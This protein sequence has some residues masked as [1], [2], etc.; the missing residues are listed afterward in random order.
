MCAEKRE[1]EMANAGRRPS[2]GGIQST[3]P[4]GAS[5]RVLGKGSLGEPGGKGPFRRARLTSEGI[6]GAYQGGPR[7][8]DTPPQDSPVPPAY[9]GSAPKRRGQVRGGNAVTHR[10]N[11]GREAHQE[12]C[13]ENCCSGTQ[14]LKSFSGER[15]LPIRK[16][17]K[18][19]DKREE[20]AQSANEGRVLLSAQVELS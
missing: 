9:P 10:P 11:E 7:P 17:Q 19:R 4:K 2:G 8:I 5:G 6:T 20:M 16:K 15:S 12:K 1:K 18:Q 14:V 13:A 3:G